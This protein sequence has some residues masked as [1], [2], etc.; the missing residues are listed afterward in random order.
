MPNKR[1]PETGKLY[2]T[3]RHFEEGFEDATGVKDLIGPERGW[4]SFT[5]Q[6]PAAPSIPEYN[7]L[8]QRIMAGRATSS[9]TGSRRAR[10]SPIPGRGR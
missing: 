7:A 6:S 3:R 4:T 8:R 10:S 5:L 1:D 2:P 9:T